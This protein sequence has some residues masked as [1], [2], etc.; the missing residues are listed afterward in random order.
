MNTRNS[1]LSLDEYQKGS[2]FWDS[3]TRMKR[4]VSKVPASIQ[5]VFY[6]WCR[7][8]PRTVSPLGSYP[9]VADAFAAAGAP[10]ADVFAP[11]IQV[12]ADITARRYADSLPSWEIAEMNEERA[13]HETNQAQIEVERNPSCPVARARLSEALAKQISAS[14][15][16]AAVNARASR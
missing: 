13:N 10:S 9:K 16:L 6:D 8:D 4:G 11:M 2:P 3:L 1:V 12:E 14:K 5:N 15:E 7:Q